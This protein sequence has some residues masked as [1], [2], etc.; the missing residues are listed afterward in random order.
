MRNAIKFFVCFI[1]VL[2]LG[3]GAAQGDEVPTSQEQVTLTF[4]PLVK[5]VAPAVVNVYAARQVTQRRSPFAGDPFFERFFGNRGFGLPR[6]QQRTARSLGSGVIVGD[7]GIVIT[8]VHV[9]QGADEVRVALRD[10]REFEAEILLA[11]ES[12]DLAV[13]K[14]DTNETLPVVPLGDSESLEV[15]DLVLALGNPFGV[16]QTV[17]SGI[18]SALARSQNGIQDFGFFI[19]T[20]ASINPGNSGGALVNMNGE[21]VGINT[22][23]FSR[24]GGSNGIGFAVPS[25]MVRVV[26]DS[27][28]S[29]ATYLVRPWVGATFQSV[30]PDIAVSL[31]MSRPQGALVAGIEEGGPAEA[32]GLRLGDVVLSLDGKMV[33]HMESL[34][35]RLATAGIGRTVK[36]GI[37]S[38]G[39]SR[40]VS[41]ELREAPEVPE[42]DVRILQDRSPFSGLEVMNLSPR[43]AQ[44]IGLQTDK[45]GVVITRIEN[46][47]AASRFGFRPKD[48]IL[49]VRD[50][51]IET[52]SDLAAITRL[53]GR[54]W[55]YVLERDGRQFRR[56]IR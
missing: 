46:N 41:I 31:G 47:S 1:F 12:S 19:Q 48:I 53:G 15:G 2:N 28:R 54:G 6:Q 17:T 22:S 34:G 27:A 24:S 51:P 21:L 23:I 16:G 9:V 30:T 26:L 55:T 45:R 36:L 32:A 4:A 42:R 29:G 18:V 40:D 38:R 5:S 37:I 8:N 3:L 49:E 56:F 13:L 35:Y 33:P 39:E 25:N 11:D 43:V 50:V 44:E 7:D 20:D 14:L 52:T 10:G